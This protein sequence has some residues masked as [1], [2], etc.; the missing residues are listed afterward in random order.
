V[1][2]ASRRL[3]FENDEV[4]SH[5][6]RAVAGT[7][8]NRLGLWHPDAFERDLAKG[9]K[10]RVQ[11]AYHRGAHWAECVRMAQWWSDYLDKLRVG[12]EVKMGKFRKR[13]Y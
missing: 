3:V 7:L 4:T 12:G 9:Q 13:T 8:L 11:A 6:F 10:D 2:V 5:R 1:N